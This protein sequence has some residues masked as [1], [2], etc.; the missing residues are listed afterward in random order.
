MCVKLAINQDV[1][2]GLMFAAIGAFGLYLASSY[3]MGTALRMGPGYFPTLLC[4]LLIAIGLG[5]SVKGIAVGGDALAR[6]HLKPLVLLAASVITFGELVGPA[7]FVA[8]TFAV[9]I[10]S[11]LAS[12]TFRPVETLLLAAVLSA[13]G[14]ALFIYGLKLPLTVWPH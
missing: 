9:V 14:V 3:P 6:W 10:L 4:W 8:A 1:V 7:G 12:P 5:I 11:A 2:A 13:C